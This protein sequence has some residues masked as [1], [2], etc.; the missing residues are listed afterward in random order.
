[1]RLQ[2]LQWRRL[3][4]DHSLAVFADEVGIADASYL[5]KMFRRR[6]GQTP[7]AFRWDARERRRPA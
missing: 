6:F 3:N 2:H 4:S 1:M 7:A 5:G